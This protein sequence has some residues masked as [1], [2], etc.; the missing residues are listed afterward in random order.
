MREWNKAEEW[1]RNSLNVSLPKTMFWQE[2]T[3]SRKNVASLKVV[4]NFNNFIWSNFI[5]LN[6]I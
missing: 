5:L 4:G 3:Y 2:I 6:F 1:Y